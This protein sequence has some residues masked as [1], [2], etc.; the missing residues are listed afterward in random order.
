MKIRNLFDS[1]EKN[2]KLV[3]GVVKKCHSFEIVFEK[4]ETVNESLSGSGKI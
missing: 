1:E 3:D 2:R 4:S